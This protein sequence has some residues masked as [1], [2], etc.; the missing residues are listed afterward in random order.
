MNPLRGFGTGWMYFSID[1]LSRR[2]KRLLDECLERSIL[3]ISIESIPCCPANGH[4][5]FILD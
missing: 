3:L 1:M 2:E 4:F 5:G